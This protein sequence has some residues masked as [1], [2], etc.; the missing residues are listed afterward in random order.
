MIK[1][2]TIRSF[3]E[4]INHYNQLFY[5]EIR[6]EMTEVGYDILFAQNDKIEIALT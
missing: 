5:T 2:I 6:Y 3:R 1:F 4:L